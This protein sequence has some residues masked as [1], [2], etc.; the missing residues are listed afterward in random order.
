MSGQ[1]DCAACKH[2]RGENI[3]V[4]CWDDP[5]KVPC[6]ECNGRNTYTEVAVPRRRGAAYLAGG[7]MTACG[8]CGHVKRTPWPARAGKE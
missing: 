6:E 5:D 3:C 8:D 1:F 2:S 4:A 7:V